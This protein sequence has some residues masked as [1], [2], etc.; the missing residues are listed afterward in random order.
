MEKNLKTCTDCNEKFPATTQ[1]FYKNKSNYKDGLHPYCKTCSKVRSRKW[2]VD[3]PDKVKEAHKKHNVKPD[4][5]EFTIECNRIRRE[6]G[7]LRKWQ[8]DNKDKLKEY[9][10]NREMHKKHDITE[11]EWVLCKMFFNYSCAY[12]GKPE[13]I[14]GQEQGQRLH[15]EHF[16]NDGENDITNCVPS[17]RS[18]NSNKRTHKFEDWYVEGNPIYSLRRLKKIN[19]WFS[20]LY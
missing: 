16:I 7:E 3:N 15:K 17:C 20:R 19:E 6:N 1:Y 11:E 9:R 8:Q 2:A 5:Y 4:R 13:S 10:L 12:C 18:C 14:V